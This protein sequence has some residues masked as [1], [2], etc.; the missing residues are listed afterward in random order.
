MRKRA[1][2]TLIELLIYVG[3][4]AI[5]AVSFSSILVT[6]SRVT[7]TQSS[8]NEV[9]TQ[10][11]FVMQNIQRMVGDASHVIVAN[12]IKDTD[13]E[14][15][16]DEIDTDL[17]TAQ[18]YLIL[19]LSA[20]DN[21]ASSQ[22]TPTIIYLDEGQVKIRKGR[23]SSNFV[24]NNLTTDKVVVDKLEFTK[25]INYPGR[26]LVEIDLTLSYNSEQEQ[27]QVAR[28]LVLGTS[29][30]YAA[31]FDT[32]LVPGVGSGA[33]IGLANQKWVDAHFSGDLT[34]GQEAKVKTLRVGDALST[35]MSAIY[36]GQ[37][38][39]N[40]PDIGDGSNKT[41]NN[42]PPTGVI[43]EVGDRIFLTP[44]KSLKAGLVL[45]GA[46]IDAD[47]NVIEI[48]SENG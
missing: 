34:V 15:T 16:W 7:I 20:D 31:T 1:G 25:F 4:F 38:D 27:F 24:I 17:G 37:L 43:L 5:L 40:P 30:A 44:H 35:P 10:L 18:K 22:T 36:N 45:V 32:N 2:F 33:S 41:F 48:S 8:R 12:S 3:I 21:S 6:F 29:K 13:L 23:G 14:E 47:D 28:K 39:V 42:S 46:T 9:A 11:S 19:K 26:D